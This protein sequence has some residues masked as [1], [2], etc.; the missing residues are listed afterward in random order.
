MARHTPIARH[1]PLPRSEF[2]LALKSK[3]HSPFS[4]GFTLSAPLWLAS[5]GAE[6]E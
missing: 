3:E 6:L 5:V 1:T 2:I 4:A